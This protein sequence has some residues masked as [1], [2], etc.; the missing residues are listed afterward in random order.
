MLVTLDSNLRKPLYL[1]IRDQLRERIVNGGL[2]AGDRLEPSRELAHQLG[3]HRT[4]VGNAYADLESEGLIQGTVGRGTFVTPL[5][6]TLRA[7]RRPSRRTSPDLFWD[8]FFPDEPRDDSLGRL[9]ASS[10]EEG[11]ISFA[12]AHGAEELTSP[13]LV[14]RAADAVLRREGGRLVQYGST[15]GYQPLKAY[16]QTRLRRDGI[17]VEVDEILVTHGCQQSL[18][19]LRRALISPGDTVVCENPTYTGLWNVF[20]PPGVRLIGVP[21][22]ADG[23]DLGAL[24]SVLEQ[25]RVKL[26]FC[27]PTFQNPT[28]FTM[29]L[30]SRQRLLELAQRFQVPIVEDDVYG[31]LR[32]RGRQIPPLKALDSAGLVIYLN[33]FSKVGFPG[34]RVGWLVASRP[35]IE[36]LRWAKQRADLHT[37]L[38]GQA[39]LQELGVRGLLDKWIRKS[40]KVYAH[41]QDVLRRAIERHFPPE[42]RVIYPDGGMSVW[43]ELPAFLDAA[44]L[45]VKARERRMLFAPSRY[46]YFQNPKHN[47]LRMCYTALPDDKIEKG[48]AI[49]GDLLKAE[50]RRAGKGRPQSP[51]GA[52]VALV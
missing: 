15:D 50:M 16:L 48:A 45:L 38:I 46:F 7:P 34:L 36:R 13:D 43:V 17:P 26:I 51:L 6:E 47:A 29:P 35:V 14:R 9:M 1:Q 42:A 33:S 41:R 37:N 49:L 32:F 31:V 19:L 22:T 11:I 10:V 28:G 3:V 18:D 39:V 25:T 27:G 12:A 21:V 24:E 4:T 30:E 8:S 2:K 52:S 23:M 20:D 5:G 40:C 44:E